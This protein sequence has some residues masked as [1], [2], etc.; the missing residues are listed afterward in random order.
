MGKFIDLTGQKFGRLIVIKRVE[1][2]NSNRPRWL[3]KCICG[4]YTIV[5]SNHLKSN[6]TKSCGCLQKEMRVLANINNK[7]GVIHGKHE[8][9][10]YRIY[11]NMKARCYNQ[12][13]KD[14]KYYGER[15]IKMCD[16]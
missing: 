6:H 16:E 14:Y 7:N 5:D 11:G 8:T 2:N 1:N 9:R 3:C 10:L 13:N 15:N 12:N 4:K